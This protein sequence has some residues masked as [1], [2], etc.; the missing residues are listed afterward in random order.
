MEIEFHAL[1]KNETWLLFR[2]VLVSISSA[3]SG[4]SKQSIV[5]MVPLSAIKYVWWLKG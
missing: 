2:H 4:C 3:P 1:F 5:V